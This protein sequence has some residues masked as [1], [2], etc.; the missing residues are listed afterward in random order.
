MQMLSHIENWDIVIIINNALRQEN[1]HE[2]LNQTLVINS[3]A[4]KVKLHGAQETPW[5]GNRDILGS[6]SC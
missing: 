1:K 4:V 3:E 2:T 5:R 6:E